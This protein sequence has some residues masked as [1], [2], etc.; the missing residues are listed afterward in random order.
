MTIKVPT[1]TSSVE[2]FK[3]P[4]GWINDP[5]GLV[6][7]EGRY[8]LFYQYYPDGLTWGPM[9][10]GH[11]VTHD[12]AHWEHKPIALTPDERGMCF[13]GSAVVDWHD[14]SGLFAGKPGLVAFYTAHRDKEGFD[15]GYI[16]E[17]CIAYSTDSGESWTK[18]SNNPVLT[19][20]DFSDFRDPKVIWHEESQHWIMCL[21]TRQT[22]SFYRSKNLLDWTFCSEFGEGQGAHEWHPWECPDLIQMH[23][24]NGT[25]AWVLIVGIGM[26]PEVHYG[27]YT[28]YFIGDFD[29]QQFTN[30]NQ[31]DTVLMLDEGRDFY[32]TQSW[33]DTPDQQHLAISWFSNWRYANELPCTQTNGQMTLP[34]QLRLVESADGLR[35]AQ[36]FASR[37][38]AEVIQPSNT[39]RLCEGTHQ[40]TQFNLADGESVLFTSTNEEHRIEVTR[41]DDRYRVDIA[42]TASTDD[43]TLNDYFAHHYSR[44]L[45]LNGPLNVEWV[46]SDAGLELLLADGLMNIT[47]RSMERS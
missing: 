38:T 2:H 36:G 6:Y 9:H 20:T 16:Q 28:Q 33:S 47:Q 5:N 11:A 32:A 42:R 8:H 7:F 23:T 14:H 37:S 12:L 30:H 46:F 26:T 44:E 45:K 25:S 29:G 34:R 18:Y 40:C 41:Q 21:A 3:A 43:K 15:R 1:L 10:W 31:P 24:D 13:S 17:Q 19:T 22:I 4:K 35:V 39:V 27:S